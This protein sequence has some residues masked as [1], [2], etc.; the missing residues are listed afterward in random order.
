MKR[1]RKNKVLLYIQEGSG[2][3]KPYSKRIK[4]WA[5]SVKS[6][7][8]KK[9][10]PSTNVRTHVPMKASETFDRIKRK[11]RRQK[12]PTFFEQIK[13]LFKK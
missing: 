2:V 4:D 10:L 9:N 12:E 5:R 8:S 13:N 1:G 3:A 11:L 6:K 7:F